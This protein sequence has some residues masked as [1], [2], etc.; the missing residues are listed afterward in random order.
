MSFLAIDTQIMPHYIIPMTC[1]YECHGAGGLLSKGAD[2]AVENYVRHHIGVASLQR[3]RPLRA[4]PPRP[5]VDHPYICFVQIQLDRGTCGLY[6]QAFG[7]L[8]FHASFKV[9]CLEPLCSPRPLRDLSMYSQSPFLISP[10]PQNCS[11]RYLSPQRSC[12]LATI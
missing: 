9:S 7:I 10:K 8:S 3:G 5:K 2:G 11:C 12:N 1:F 6:W 4:Y